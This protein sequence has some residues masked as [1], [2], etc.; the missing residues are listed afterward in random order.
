M[1]G[2]FL[3]V[4]SVALAMKYHLMLDFNDHIKL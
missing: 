1:I 2:F 4:K 3:I